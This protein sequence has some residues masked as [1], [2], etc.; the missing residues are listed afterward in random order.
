MPR[1]NV[2]PKHRIEEAKYVSVGGIDQWVTIRGVDDRKPVLLLLHGGPG[3]VQSPYVTTYSPFEQEF[4]LVQWDQRGSGRTFAKSGLAGLTLEKQ[5]SDGIDLAEQLHARFPG[6]KLILL[7]HSWGT[8]VATGMA[9]QRPDLFASYV[10]TGQVAAW[11]D[12]VQFQFEF[13]EQR[14]KETGNV[15]GLADLKKI[16][17][18]DPLNIPQYFNFSRPLRQNLG[19]ADTKWFAEMKAT[20]MINGETEASI[21]TAGDGQAASAGALIQSI[22]RT[23]L[24]ATAPAFKLPYCVIQ[25]RDDLNAPTELAQAYFDKVKVPAKAMAVIPNGGHFSMATNQAA[26]IAAL[27]KCPGVR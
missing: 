7:G 12:T 13:L 17:K 4:V 26:F 15:K 14:Y 6:R 21:K 20:A 23:D 27:K 8:V 10:G 5:V 11:A 1:S 9:Q 3:D 18:P 25:G 19:P 24:P 2:A 22:F 16:G